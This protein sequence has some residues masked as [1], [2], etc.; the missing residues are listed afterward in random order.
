LASTFVVA[1]LTAACST[2][3]I[4]LGTNDK[5]VV[6][7]NAA[8]DSGARS[9]YGCA[10][11]RD[12][13]VAALRGE[14]CPDSI[15]PY[16]ANASGVRYDVRTAEQTIAITAGRWMF[17]GSHPFS[18]VPDAVG[19]EFTGGCIVYLLRRDRAQKLVRGT[20]A[21][22]QFS[23]DVEVPSDSTRPIAL[24][25]HL[26]AKQSLRLVVASAKCPNNWLRLGA[27][28]PKQT[29]VLRSPS[30]DD[31]VPPPR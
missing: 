28:N 12:D 30:P 16:M 25:L 8:F 11:W 7:Q 24:D 26:N 1:T 19:I 22:Y 6:A 13:D 29:L 27:V 14:G 2:Q 9:F 18:T 5:P 21:A 15:C 3:N 17:C 4:D 31:L 10:T 20:E 23:F